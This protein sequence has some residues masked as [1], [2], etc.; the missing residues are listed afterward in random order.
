MKPL[1]ALAAL[2]ALPLSF[3][4]HALT[5]NGL[6]W[7][8]PFDSRFLSP[9]ELASACDPGGTCHG[10]VDF[11]NVE[12]LV[13]ASFDEVKAMLGT[14][15]PPVK[16]SSDWSNP[17]SVSYSAYH[18]D[19]ID[20]AVGEINFYATKTEPAGGS[21]RVGGYTRDKDSVGDYYGMVITN[22]FGPNDSISQDTVFTTSVAAGNQDS[23]YG[24]WLYRAP[25]AVPLPAAA[26][27]LLSGLG[28][29]AAVARRRRLTIS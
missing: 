18:S 28:G 4:A 9:N 11:V 23:L 19:Y 12:G 8:Q 14:L 22:Y 7:Q 15:I 25:A 10:T 5:I 21:E 16:T 1:R 13:W 29:V 3:S 26:W 2:L 20:L 6:D 24:A 27:L 17:R